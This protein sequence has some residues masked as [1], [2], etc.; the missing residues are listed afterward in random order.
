M[1]LNATAELLWFL[2]LFREGLQ[3]K[4]FGGGEAIPINS[5]ELVDTSALE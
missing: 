4:A 3:R 1:Q 2:H 5:Y